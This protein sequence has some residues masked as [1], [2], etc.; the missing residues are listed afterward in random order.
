MLMEVAF[1][2]TEELDD[3]VND[4]QKYG[5]TN[6]QIVFSTLLDQRNVPVNGKICPKK[7]KK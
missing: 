6:T 5:K 1:S 3:F 4:L 2:N 7:M